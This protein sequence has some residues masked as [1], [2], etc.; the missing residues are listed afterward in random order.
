M[1]I[2]YFAAHLSKYGKPGD[3]PLCGRGVRRTSGISVPADRWLVEPRICGHCARTATGK[4][5]IQASKDRT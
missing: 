2:P 1:S 5:L 4:R 3:P